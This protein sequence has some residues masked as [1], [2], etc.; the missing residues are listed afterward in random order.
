MPEDKLELYIRSSIEYENIGYFENLTTAR[1]P[2]G[3]RMFSDYCVS[4]IK[5]LYCL[6]FYCSADEQ[7]IIVEY[8]YEDCD[9]IMY[10]W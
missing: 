7:Q 4:T 3:S 6:P 5:E 1:F 10:N 8:T 9:N 2:N